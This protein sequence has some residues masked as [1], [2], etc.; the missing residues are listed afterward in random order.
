MLLGTG[1][2]VGMGLVYG[3][4]DDMVGTAGMFCLGDDFEIEVLRFLTLK[5]Q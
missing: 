3:G 1:E 4:G 2:E 5:G